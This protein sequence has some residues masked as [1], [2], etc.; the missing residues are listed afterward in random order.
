MNDW[1]F[2][3]VNVALYSLIANFTCSML[4]H[5]FFAIKNFMS[6]QTS[7]IGFKSGD[8]AGASGFI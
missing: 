8:C 5:I 3:G 7:S 2:S 6:A 4:E 1:H